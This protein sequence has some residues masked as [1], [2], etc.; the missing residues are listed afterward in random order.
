[1]PF[2][3]WNVAFRE[4]VSEFRELLREYPGTRRELRVAFSLRERFS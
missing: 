1:M 2:Q 3:E 4:S